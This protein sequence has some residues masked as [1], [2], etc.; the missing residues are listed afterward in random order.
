MG[1]LKC[2]FLVGIP[3]SGKSTFAENFIKENPSYVRVS[4]DG[5]RKMLCDA[6]HT[7]E[8]KEGM[9]EEL[10]LSTIIFS[11]SKNCNV[12]VD[13]TN[14]ELSRINKMC[15]QIL[16][17]ADVDFKVF[18]VSLD[19]CFYRNSKRERKIPKDIIRQKHERFEILKTNFDFA[20]RDKYPNRITPLPNFDSELPEAICFDID[21]TL[22]HMNGRLPFEWDK[23]D[24]DIYS[25]IVGELIE[26]HKSKGRTIIILSGRDSSCRKLTEEW[27]EKHGLK[28]DVLYMREVNDTR[29]DSAVK[30]EI[31]NNHIKDKYNLLAVVDDRLS[32]LKTW[33]ELGI[34]SFNVNQGNKPF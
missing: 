2:T 32:V 13:N 23:V 30:K 24:T 26:F 22:A 28:Y 5:F 29:R 7:D 16:E 12:L 20:P 27:L 34:F 19:E 25:P 3:A 21:G 15:K 18:D 4:S 17:Y 14:C 9:I 6:Q 31:Y 11:L 8:K 33:Y 10:T 1:N